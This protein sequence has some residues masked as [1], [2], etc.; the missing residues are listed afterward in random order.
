MSVLLSPPPG[1]QPSGRSWSGP[2]NLLVLLQGV[3]TALNIY[4]ITTWKTIDQYYGLFCVYAVPVESIWV[5]E[6]SQRHSVIGCSAT[7]LYYNIIIFHNNTPQTQFW[8]LVLVHHC[9]SVFKCWWIGCHVGRGV[10][11][12]RLNYLLGRFFARPAGGDITQPSTGRNCS[13]SQNRAVEPSLL[14]GWR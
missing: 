11:Y 6:T 8:E 13:E 10:F 5:M 1:L 14:R 12:S 3:L 4:A 7:I 9:R 2:G